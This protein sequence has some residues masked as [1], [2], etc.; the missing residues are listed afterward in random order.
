M[1][2]GN[3]PIFIPPEDVG[4]TIAIKVGASGGG[5]LEIVRCEGGASAE[6]GELA[7]ARGV[8]EQVPSGG[9][10][11]DEGG[12]ASNCGISSDAGE[13]RASVEGDGIE[14]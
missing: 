11:D 9:A 12:A 1:P 2:S 8:V 7:A 5:E 4:F 14:D 6:G 3:T 10:V 13:T